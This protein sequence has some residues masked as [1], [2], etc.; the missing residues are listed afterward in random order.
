MRHQ[1]NQASNTL[2]ALVSAPTVSL[3]GNV[4]RSSSQLKQVLL[5][6]A[7]VQIPDVF[8]KFQVVQGLIDPA[9]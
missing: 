2:V 9:A 3:S 6:T 8:G 4:L 7:I 5:G 1:D